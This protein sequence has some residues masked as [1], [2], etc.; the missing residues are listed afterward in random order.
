[1]QCPAACGDITLL[2]NSATGC[3]PTRREKTLSRIAF[4]LCSTTLPEPLEGNIKPLFDSGDI[5]ASM[6]L[7]NIVL[8]DPNISE[9][10]MDE[11]SPMDRKTDTREITFE[12]RFAV[13]KTLTTSPVTT[14]AYWDYDFW[15]DKLNN[16][17]ALNYMLIYCDGDVVIPKNPNGSL[18][19]ATLFVYLSAQKP[20]TQGGS[21][22]EFK[23]GSIIFQGDPWSLTTAKPAFNL[24]DEGIIL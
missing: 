14:D 19:K 16:Q 17:T 3:A 20:T 7:A 10:M 9:I 24:N 6:P 2:S 21:W 5:V 1:M 12:D 13:T 8:N 18:M 15:Q 4:F 23:R 11:C 22:I